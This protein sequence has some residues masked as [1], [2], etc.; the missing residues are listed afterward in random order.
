MRFQAFKSS[1]GHAQFPAPMFS[2]THL[3]EPST[4]HF[5]SNTIKG[6]LMMAQGVFLP[7]NIDE[8]FAEDDLLR[9]YLDKT[10]G[11]HYNMLELCDV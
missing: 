4:E 9:V 7:D 10:F 3:F 6:G 2:M 11:V 1:M 8:I 5:S